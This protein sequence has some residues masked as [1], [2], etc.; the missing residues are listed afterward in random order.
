MVHCARKR[1]TKLRR[2][3]RVALEA[4]VPASARQIRCAPVAANVD[5]GAL[6][7]ACPGFMAGGHNEQVS[8]T[9]FQRDDSKKEKG[10]SLGLSRTEPDPRLHR[11]AV[12]VKKLRTVRYK[13][14]CNSNQLTMFVVCHKHERSQAKSKWLCSPRSVHP[15]P[16]PA[17]RGSACRHV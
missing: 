10:E 17:F 15:C 5:P 13:I 11:E 9:W 7:C 6:A 16:S 14:L 2:A 12:P 8:I 4:A 3:R 1:E